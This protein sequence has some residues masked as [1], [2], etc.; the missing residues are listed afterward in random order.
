MDK[1][2]KKIT[3]MSEKYGTTFKTMNDVKRFQKKYGLKVDGKIGPKTEAKI[4][5]LYDKTHKPSKYKLATKYTEKDK[6]AQGVYQLDGVEVTVPQLSFWEKQKR[7]LANQWADFQKNNPIFGST[8][9]EVAQKYANTDFRKASDDVA[10]A[11]FDLFLLASSV[12]PATKIGK[13]LASKEL[14]QILAKLG[15]SFAG[16]ELGAMTFDELYKQITGKSYYEAADEMG[17]WDINKG[18][19]NPGGW[20]GGYAASYTADA[21]PTMVKNVRPWFEG[22]F[23]RY[24]WTPEGVIE[25]QPGESYTPRLPESQNTFVY[26]N[27]FTTKTGGAGSSS[28]QKGR[29]QRTGQ[30]ATSGVQERVMQDTKTT[31]RGKKGK[32][33][34]NE[35]EFAPYNLEPV[36]VPNVTWYN[37]PQEVP[38]VVIVPP[39]PQPD[40]RLEEYKPYED[41]FLKWFA[42]QPRGTT[43]YYEGDE[44][45]APGWYL[46][47]LAKADPKSTTRV[48]GDSEGYIIPDSTSIQY[49]VVVPEQINM[50]EGGVPAEAKRSN[51]KITGYKIGGKL[52]PKQLKYGR[53]K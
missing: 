53:R 32:T 50:L 39:T 15:I 6:D 27:R 35:V 28:G 49:N 48:V 3:E 36:V 18:L 24:A 5:E 44:V 52:I 47:K 14:P 19:T 31:K 1:W 42:Q 4:K 22:Q 41:P 11:I 23:P 40:Y 9:R 29:V 20:M 2:L 26:K 46:I 51:E 34:T 16:A 33:V 7:S 30:G 45:H 12:G 37:V 8:R 25:L 10:N 17:L 43:Q 13:A 38:P 21:F